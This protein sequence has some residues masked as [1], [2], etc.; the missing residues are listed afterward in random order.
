M[1][2]YWLLLSPYNDMQNWTDPC[3]RIQVLQ[4]LHGSMPYACML[5]T[6]VLGMVLGVLVPVVHMSVSNSAD[7]YGM[8]VQ[9]LQTLIE[10][11]LFVT[12]AIRYSGS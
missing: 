1:S 3:V 7:V 9:L 11:W 10:G 8:C 6:T 4:Q 5:L 12:W 2:V